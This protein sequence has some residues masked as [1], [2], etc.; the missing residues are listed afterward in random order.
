MKNRKAVKRVLIIAGAVLAV[1]GAALFVINFIHIFRSPDIHFSG[2]FAA[3]LV[4]CAG[5]VPVS[6]GLL[7]H[8]K[9]IRDTKHGVSALLK[10]LGLFWLI[11]GGANIIIIIVISLLF[12]EWLWGA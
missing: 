1:A 9:D 11:G 4:L 12:G 10:A 8:S 7:M 2:I 5:L 6:V 3:V